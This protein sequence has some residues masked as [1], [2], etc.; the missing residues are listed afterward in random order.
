MPA[1]RAVLAAAS[2]YFFELF[3]SKNEKPSRK[4]EEVTSGMLYSLNGGFDK[5]SLEVLV[6]YA[7]TAR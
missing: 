7:Y 2:P 6:D 1:H 3:T 4:E 5:R